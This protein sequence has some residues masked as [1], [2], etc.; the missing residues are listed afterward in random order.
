MQ[1]E[2]LKNSAGPLSPIDGGTDSTTWQCGSRRFVSC[3]I[4]TLCK[5]TV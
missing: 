2:W 4:R 5:A 3:P 1:P